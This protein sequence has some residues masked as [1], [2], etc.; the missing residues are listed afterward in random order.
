VRAR[1]SASELGLGCVLGRGEKREKDR[2]EG[3]ER[4]VGDGPLGKGDGPRGRRGELGCKTE[5]MGCRADFSFLSPFL[6]FFKLTQFYLNS[7]EIGIQ[8]YHSN[9]QKRCTSMNAQ[10]C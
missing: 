6:F 2:A 7:N 10:T 9:K 5:G 1:P 4:G 3:K 8:T